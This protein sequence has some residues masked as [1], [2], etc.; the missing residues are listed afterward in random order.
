MR[1]T[2]MASSDLDQAARAGAD[3]MKG[4][5]RQ[6]GDSVV[7]LGEGVA[8]IAMGLQSMNTGLRAT[9]ML[10]EQ[11]KKDLDELRARRP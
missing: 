2:A 4:E 9:Y 6:S 7:Y 5:N 10:L 11:I 8:H 3:A 1:P